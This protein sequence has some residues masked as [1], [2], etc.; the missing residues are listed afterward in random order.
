[1]VSA[2]AHHGRRVVAYTAERRGAATENVA[3]V[4][5]R[6]EEMALVISG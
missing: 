5:N 4:M 6:R 2:V 1:M 3:E